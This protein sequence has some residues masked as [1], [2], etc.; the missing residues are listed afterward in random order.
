MAKEIVMP[1]LGET[2]EEGTITKWLVEEGQTIKKGDLIM[3]VETDK[4][5]LEVESLV[6]GDL[7]KIVVE[8]G[9]AVP[10][11]TVVGYAGQEGDEL[12]SEDKS[13]QQAEPQIQPEVAPAPAPVE[14]TDT[15][16]AEA[17]SDELKISPRA[18]KLAIKLGVD[19]AKIPPPAGKNRLTA[20]DV[21][22]FY[23]N[24]NK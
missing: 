14:N 24:L 1:K 23:D 19:I 15:P 22:D 7:L 3:E 9:V 6:E 21:Q 17:E 10:I 11:G 12:P 5:T 16:P 2:M 20:N 8:E 4:V 18:L 13:V